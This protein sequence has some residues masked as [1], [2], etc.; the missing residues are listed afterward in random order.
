MENQS[1]SHATVLGH[2]GV[3]ILQIH[4]YGL[5]AICKEISTLAW[6]E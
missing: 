1:Q 4:D 3:Q 2:L 5:V 6:S